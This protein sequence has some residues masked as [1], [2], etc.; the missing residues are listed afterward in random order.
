MEVFM[1]ARRVVKILHSFT[2]L[3]FESWQATSRRQE[4]RIRTDVADQRGLSTAIRR[5][6]ENPGF[7][8]LQSCVCR[9]GVANLAARARRVRNA[10]YIANATHNR[11]LICFIACFSLILSTQPTV[12]AGLGKSAG[13]PRA[14]LTRGRPGLNL[15]NLNE[16]RRMSS[17]IPKIAPPVSAASASEVG[18]PAPAPPSMQDDNLAMAMLAPM[19][20]VGTGR[21]DLLSRNYNWGLPL[22][23]LPGRAGLDL[24]LTL[25][26]NSLIWT[27]SGGNIHFD[28]SGFP[29]TGFH[30]GFP[31][32]KTYFYN[33]E[34]GVG[35]R[36]V[37]M[38]SGERYEF[39]ENAALEDGS[40]YVY[41][42]RNGSNMIIVEVPG[43]F[44]PSETV[45]SLLTPDGTAYK[46]VV[47]GDDPKCVQ[48][49]DRNG[50]Y[51]SVAYNASTEKITKITDTAAREVNFNYD[52]ANRLTS[53]TQN[54]GGGTHTWATFTYSTVTIS[55]GFLSL[56]M[57][58]AQN[59][60]TI[61]VLSR[62]G[63]ADGCIYSFD[64]NTY[65]QVYMVHRYEPK[66]ATSSSFPDD[67]TQ[68]SY[69]TYDLPHDGSG[70]QNDCPRFY[71]RTDWAKDWNN[72]NEVNTTFAGDLSS[73]GSVST[74]DGVLYK[75]FFG[76]AGTW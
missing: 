58:G 47:V 71:T 37:I 20:R 34:A 67:Y 26:L 74:P 22:I 14:H 12:P 41:E 10:R 68:L 15:P 76:A 52:S 50:N 17:V 38:P 46:Y 73:W 18:P 27:K 6:R 3:F 70:Q 61:P 72:N 31:E 13:K 7:L 62:V 39:W 19:N 30:L 33:S 40:A 9:F 16:A 60:Q 55:A 51:I 64:Y 8:S 69:V 53:I 21:E 29:A 42:E 5:I 44:D 43:L 59:G 2:A 48:M 1:F 54:W 63:L 4:P 65:G 57:V 56:N 45:W 75:E 24:N 49:E 28:N 25:S 11:R 32:L 23:G 66:T 35:S 36:L